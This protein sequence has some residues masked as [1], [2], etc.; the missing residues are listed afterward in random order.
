[1][2]RYQDQGKILITGSAGRL[3]KLLVRRLHRTDSVVGLDRRPFL[4][5]PKDVEFYELDIRRKKCEDVFRTQKIKAVVHLNILHNPRA[6]SGQHHAVNM[7]GTQNLLEYCQRYDVPKLIF[8]S[9]ANV[10]GAHPGNNQF[11]TEDAPLLGAES[12]HEIRDLVAVDMFVQSFF[13]KYPETET[14]VLR[15][16]H[17]LG[18]VRNAASNYLRLNRIPTLLGFD[19][20]VQTIAEEDVISAIVRALTPGIRGVFNIAGPPAVP[21][22]T[23][24]RLTEKPTFPAPHLAFR[25]LV[26]QLWRYRLTSFPAP[27]LDYIRYVCAVDDTLARTVLGYDHRYSVDDM[28]KCALGKKLCAPQ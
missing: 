24:I 23:L 1:M 25:Q 3:G 5:R 6:D 21:L 26:K 18:R 9:S 22:S 28:V 15:P 12:F 2:S 8:L 19:P 20:M 11:L 27:E 13:W 7:L 14:V 4:D 17:I 10:Y 16:V